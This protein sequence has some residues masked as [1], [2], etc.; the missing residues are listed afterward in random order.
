MTTR[1]SIAN[2]AARTMSRRRVLGLVAACGLPLLFGV[3]ATRAAVGMPVYRWRGRALGATAQITLLHPDAA[4]ARAVVER[5]IAEVVRLESIFSLYQGESEISRFNRDGRLR[6]ASLDM[7]L[8][9]A[10][11]RRFGDLTCGAFDITVQPLW[12]L[13]ARHFAAVGPG[14]APP[15]VGVLDD[16]RRHVGYRRIDID[17]ADAG[18]L[19]AGME[20]TLNGI[21]QGYITD[22]IV[23]MLRNEGFDQV[24]ADLGEIAALDAPSGEAGWPVVVDEPGR[25]RHEGTALRLANQ[26]IATSSGGATKFDDVGR[27]NH[28]FDPRTGQSANAFRAVSVIARSAMVSDAL[29]T[30]LSVLP[31]ADARRVLREVGAERALYWNGF[32]P[33]FEVA[34]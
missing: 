18:F 30:A 17:G 34:A 27:Y 25:W 16:V 4:A 19:E 3:N 29:S 15:P 32:G 24:L 5:C 22:R 31:I 21:A 23:T 7:R 26:A 6:G 1:H 20:V 14:G 33:A 9:L 13:Y 11:S 28:L 12:R 2:A 10:E 8:L